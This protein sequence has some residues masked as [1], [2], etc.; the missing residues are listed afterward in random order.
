MSSVLQVVCANC[1]AK[2]KL[3]ESF[4]KP[5]AKCTKCGS[6]IDVAAQ[7][8]AAA[9]SAPT[10]ETPAATR[11][12][13][14]RP[15]KARAAK[16]SAAETAPERPK[17]GSSAGGS[18]RRRGRG[19]RD[20][21]DDASET[22]GRRGRKKNDA[23]PVAVYSGIG[24]IVLALG[25]VGYL[26]FSGGKT[27][28]E[29]TANSSGS[30]TTAATADTG[31]TP[32]SKPTEDG[33]AT[34]ETA[35]TDE[36]TKTAE[37]EKDAP[38][39]AD[40]PEPAKKPAKSKG[41]QTMAE[42]YNPSKELEPLAWPDDIS[43][44]DKQKA[45]DALAKYDAQGLP[46]IRAKKMLV[47]DLPYPGA[48]A[49]VEKLRSLDYTT[50]KAQFGAFELVKLMKDLSGGKPTPYRAVARDGEVSVADADWN[51][52]TVRAWHSTLKRITSKSEFTEF[53]EKKSK[54]K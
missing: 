5:Q 38:A 50:N 33:A 2:Y 4:Q 18:K 23:S 22:R 40:K 13:S 48:F 11:P 14:A 19:A 15:A 6:T 34:A 20:R 16:A 1:G 46:W 39:T 35:S 32:T 42:I 43:S 36:G 41:P 47:N 9:G 26:M 30:G 54:K 29:E 28:T 49:T 24:V 53:V 31:T 3:P 27:V 51:A 7:R 44:D 10:T 45:M 21:D 17:R 8:A 37:T 52:K 25:V 12:A